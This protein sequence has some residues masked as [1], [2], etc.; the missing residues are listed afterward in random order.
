VL[1]PFRPHEV[2]VLLERDAGSATA[3]SEA[4]YLEDRRRRLA[5][6]GTWTSWEILFAVEGDGRL[7]GELQARFSRGVLPHGVYE[8]GIELYEEGDR[9]RGLGS[10]AV[11]LAT[12][13]LFAE[14]EAIRVQASTAPDNAAMRR[15][16]QKN[17]FTFE[18]ILRG[19]MPSADG[20]RDYALYA[21]TR[22][23]WEETN[24]WTSTS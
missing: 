1:R 2:D 5:L 14:A 9:G 18:G 19:F 15:S 3:R 16:L 4:D 20:P 21:M 8:L 13:H 24:G 23:D 17:G 22:K 11:R 10:E 7:V 12:D 6:S